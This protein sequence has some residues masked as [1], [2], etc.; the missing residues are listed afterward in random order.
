M[1]GV[2]LA[3][4]LAFGAG[5]DQGLKMRGG[6][7]ASVAEAAVAG[8]V[9]GTIAAGVLALVAGLRRLLPA[10]PRTKAWALAGALALVVFVAAE[11][12]VARELALRFRSG[13][14]RAGRGGGGDL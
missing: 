8:L 6:G 11:F 4:I 9:W 7:I 2:A 13:S 1:T 3:A 5:V 12:A 14:R 10:E